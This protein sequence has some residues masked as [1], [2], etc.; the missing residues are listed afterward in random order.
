MNEVHCLEIEFLCSNFPT[1]L[2]IF[3]VVTENREVGNALY[4]IDANGVEY[5]YVRDDA[6][7]LVLF[8]DGDGYDYTFTYNQDGLQTSSGYPD[9]T[10]IEFTYDDEGHLQSLVNP[11]SST[12]N[13]AYDDDDNLVSNKV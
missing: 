9:S 11:D 1:V 4:T 7:N 12:I 13:F 6:E 5:K 3:Q 8:E 10:R 2:I